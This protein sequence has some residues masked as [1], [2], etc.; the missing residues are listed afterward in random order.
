MQ[1]KKRVQ[2]L[3]RVLEGTGKWVLNLAS[4]LRAVLCKGISWAGDENLRETGTDEA[5]EKRGY[6][7]CNIKQKNTSGPSW[8]FRTQGL[9]NVTSVC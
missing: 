9:E 1:L 3:H 5:E 7:Y 6:K 2:G 8:H 4:H